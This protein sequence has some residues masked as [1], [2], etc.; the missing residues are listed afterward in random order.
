MF[1]EIL[2]QSYGAIIE[3]PL[4]VADSLRIIYQAVIDIINLQNYTI[5]WNRH[6]RIKCVIL[7]KA[8]FTLFYFHLF[9]F[10]YKMCEFN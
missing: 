6:L 10:L 1:F 4:H 8:L 5:N 2:K 7:D 9:I 3:Q